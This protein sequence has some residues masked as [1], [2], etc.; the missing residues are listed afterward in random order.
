MNQPTKKELTTLAARAIKEHDDV[1]D[2]HYD[3]SVMDGLICSECA[4]DY[5]EALILAR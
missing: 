3:H 1:C 5:H 4:D 2:I